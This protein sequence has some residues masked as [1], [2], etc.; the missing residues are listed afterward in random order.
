[1]L[2]TGCRVAQRKKLVEEN[3]RC[4][5]GGLSD[6]YGSNG[7]VSGGEELISQGG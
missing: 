3:T 7:R 1:M 6:G 5:G 4:E 2:K